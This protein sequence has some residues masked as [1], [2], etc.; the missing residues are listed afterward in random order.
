MGK[1]TADAVSTNM[2]IDTRTR[3]FFNSVCWVTG[4][5]LHL[6][7]LQDC[8]SV[9]LRIDQLL[10]ITVDERHVPT[11]FFVNTWAFAMQ[12]FSIRLPYSPEE[13]GKPGS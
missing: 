5:I 1:V 12:Y 13:L 4:S 2:D 7:T 11:G 8:F 9:D 3:A 6:L 10:Q